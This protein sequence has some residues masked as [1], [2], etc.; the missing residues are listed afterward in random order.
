MNRPDKAP[1]A[2]LEALT[3]TLQGDDLKHLNDYREAV[4][5]SELKNYPEEAKS[6][7]GPVIHQDRCR[8]QVEAAKEALAQILSSQADAQLGAPSRS[9]S[10]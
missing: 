8:K 5:L 7:N 10:N 1:A 2:V 9:S 3:I 6:G 4:Y